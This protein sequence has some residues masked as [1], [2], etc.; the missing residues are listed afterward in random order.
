[1]NTPKINKLKLVEYIYK[2]RN[3]GLAGLIVSIM[4]IS[5]LTMVLSTGVT[6]VQTENSYNKSYN[7]IERAKAAAMSGVFYYMGCLLATSSTFSNN[8]RLH[9]LSRSD[10]NRS[11]IAN[12]QI[13]TCSSGSGIA[14]I[15]LNVATSAWMYPD[16]I[17]LCPPNS[18]DV[19]SSSIFIIKTY[20][21]NTSN[22]TL[23]SYVYIKSL[24]CYREIEGD[25]I[26]ASYY[27][28]IIARI[29]INN[30][31]KTLTLVNWRYMPI[32]YPANEDS[33]FHS[34]LILPFK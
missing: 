13:A 24:G 6:V 9:F 12:Q 23:A 20:V 26:I 19:P 29:E 22:N 11:Q 7:T 33:A 21:D 5:Y 18:D 34:Q 2:I 1:M 10:K 25:N 30:L 32:Q 27:S 14:F 3:K 15:A 28:Q 16:I 4:I 17:D 8:I 31:K